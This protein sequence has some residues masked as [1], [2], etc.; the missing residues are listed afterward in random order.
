MTT[1]TTKIVNIIL[2]VVKKD[3][4][5]PFSI[6]LNDVKEGKDYIIKVCNYRGDNVNAPE[7]T[8]PAFE[9]AAKE[10]LSWIELDV[11]QTSDG[12][13]IC[14]H[15]SCHSILSISII[16]RMGNIYLYKNIINSN[17]TIIYRIYNCMV[18]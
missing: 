4:R 16:K 8:M 12:I 15:D 18:I 17:I 6:S 14:S 5:M 7:N 13:I 10:N 1:L 11:H 9:L 3:Y 2:A